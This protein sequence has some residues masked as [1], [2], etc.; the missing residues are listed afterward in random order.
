MIATTTSVTGRD[1]LEAEI[2]RLFLDFEI[3]RVEYLIPRTMV[4][5]PQIVGAGFEHAESGVTLAST[6][7]D[8]LSVGWFQKGFEDGLWIS[9][10]P[11]AIPSRAITNTAPMPAESWQLE[12]TPRAVTGISIG[13]QELEPSS[14]SLWTIRLDLGQKSVVLALGERDYE[15]G[16]A[17]FI[18]NCVIAIFDKDVARQYR[19]R[20][21]LSSAWAESS[22]ADSSG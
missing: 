11:S 12:D 21:C 1:E 6:N 2:E 16:L 19:P 10:D 8:R 14:W 4:G 13:W 22:S 15:S 17:T 5:Q 9:P 18:P 7:G 3:A 20:H